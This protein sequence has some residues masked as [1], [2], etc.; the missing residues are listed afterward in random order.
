MGKKVIFCFD[1]SEQSE[2]DAVIRRMRAVEEDK[3]LDPDNLDVEVIYPGDVAGNQYMTWSGTTPD[4]RAKGILENLNPEDKIYIWGHG[5]PNSG[6]I[7]GAYYT[8]IADYIDKGVNKDNFGPGKGALNI[9]VE[10]CNGGRGG[11][12]GQDSFAARLHSLLGKKG[13]YSQV[14]GRLKNVALDTS[15]LALEGIKTIDRH[16]DGLRQMGVN[17]SEDNYKRHGVRSKVTYQWDPSDTNQQL[18]VDNY[19][20]SLRTGF[21]KVKRNILDK[22]NE[23]PNPL[24]DPRKLHR[25][26]LTV[27]LNLSDNAEQLKLDIIK[28]ATKDLGALCRSIGMSNQELKDMGLEHF[29]HSLD[30]KAHTDGFLRERTNVS[31]NAP[32]LDVERQSLFDAVATHPAFQ[33]LHLISNTIAQSAEH[34]DFANDIIGS[35]QSS[36][37]DNLYGNF[38]MQCRKDIINNHD[39][40]IKIDKN[41]TDAIT[42]MNQLLRATFID[43]KDQAQKLDA[44]KE[45]KAKL[46]DYKE[47]S[48]IGKM[49]S[50]FRGAACGWSTAWKERHEASVLEWLPNLFKSAYDFGEAYIERYKDGCNAISNVITYCDSHIKAM[51]ETHSD[52]ATQDNTNEENALP[53]ENTE[54]LDIATLSNRFDDI[55]YDIDAY[56][57]R[58]RFNENTYGD[59]RSFERYISIQVSAFQHEQATNIQPQHLQ[60]LNKEINALGNLLDTIKE[61]DLVRYDN[62]HQFPDSIKKLLSHDNDTDF[63]ERPLD[64]RIALDHVA[65][66]A[67]AAYRLEPLIDEEDI[68]QLLDNPNLRSEVIQCYHQEHLSHQDTKVNITDKIN[69]MIGLI[70]NQIQRIEKAD[71]KAKVGSIT[72]QKLKMLR[73]EAQNL[74]KLGDFVDSHGNLSAIR[75]Q[76]EIITNDVAE[77]ANMQR[78]ILGNTT[79]AKVLAH[80]DSDFVNLKNHVLSHIDKATKNIANPIAKVSEEEERAAN[81]EE[82][83][84]RDDSISM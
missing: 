8:E 57:V 21:I 72:D 69:D 46:D 60:Q 36:G 48:T 1:S 66:A 74:A 27:E 3:G 14:T 4:A 83:D 51:S 68:C 31:R 49:T 81:E 58:H 7:P 77:A 75:K 47:E 71:P 11:E 40:K 84:E 54:P 9:T 25:L 16:M 50:W 67:I 34:R 65:A 39:G 56:R 59:F 28:N 79:S 52:E 17:I 23:G 78:G 20:L 43:N 35:E 13:V 15:T 38:F 24:L 73:N 6:Y 30:D 61:T 62:I 32:L 44:L 33:E 41:V 70:E 10:I 2:V 55:R 12:Q 22:V 76:L 45:V 37:E 82:R 64:A 53:Q 63:Q 19:R 26:L 29:H 18:R 5:S 42:Q 80:P